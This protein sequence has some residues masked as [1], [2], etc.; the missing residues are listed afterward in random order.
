MGTEGFCD[1]VGLGALDDNGCIS[2]DDPGTTFDARSPSPTAHRETC[3]TLTVFG[4]FVF[5]WRREIRIRFRLRDRG[6]YLLGTRSSE[7]YLKAFPSSTIVVRY[8]QSL[9]WAK[10]QVIIGKFYSILPSLMRRCN[11][12]GIHEITV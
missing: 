9:E 4:Y 10:A 12:R 6:S 5:D 7:S 11:I 3:C 8:R 1:A 2:R